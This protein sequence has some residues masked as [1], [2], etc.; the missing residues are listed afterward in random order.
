MRLF[1]STIAVSRV[2]GAGGENCQWRTAV[3]GW[4]AQNDIRATAKSGPLY[5]GFISAPEANPIDPGGTGTPRNVHGVGPLHTSFCS[6]A[7]NTVVSGVTVEVS[8]HEP[9]VAETLSSSW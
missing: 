2:G 9:E 6:S 7:S 4:V 1:W 8:T 5:A 3:P